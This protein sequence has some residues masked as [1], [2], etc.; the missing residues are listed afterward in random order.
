MDKRFVG[1]ILGKQDYYSVWLGFNGVSNSDYII[2][3]S[4]G[5]ER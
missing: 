1:E 4:K 2:Y 5:E 3:F